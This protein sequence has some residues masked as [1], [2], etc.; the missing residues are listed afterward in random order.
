MIDLKREIA[1]GIIRRCW[2]REKHHTIKVECRSQGEADG[3]CLR[4]FDRETVRGGQRMPFG[5]NLDD[6]IVADDRD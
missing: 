3:L 1:A 2:R 4:Q 6:E 5:I